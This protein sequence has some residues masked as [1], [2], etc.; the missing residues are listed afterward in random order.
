MNSTNG[1]KESTMFYCGV[2]GKHMTVNTHGLNIINTCNN[3]E[4]I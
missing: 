1:T 4:R 2:Y 3:D